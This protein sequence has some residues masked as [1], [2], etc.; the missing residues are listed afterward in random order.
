M[1]LRQYFAIVRKWWWL[2]A[3]TTLLATGTAYYVSSSAPPVYRATATLQIDRGGDPR[4]DPT[5]VIQTSEAIAST[6][7][8][9]IKSP[10]LL[11]EVRERLGV[12]MSADK[13][14]EMLIVSQMGD[15]QLINITA[16]GHDPTF[17]K[18]LVDMVAQVFIERETASQEAR[19]QAR[20]SEL[21]AQV[22]TLEAD[23]EET[24]KAI[25]SLGDPDELPEFAQLELARL[26]S[27]RSN[28][29]TRLMILLQS[30]EEFR[31]AMARYTTRIDIFDPAELPKEPVG[32]EVLQTTGLAAVTGLMIGAGVAFLLEYLDDT[33]KTP[34]DAKR[35]L[36]VNVLG[37][38]PRHDD[39][40]ETLVTVKRP[41]GPISEA[42]RKLRTSIQF[43]DLDHPMRTLLVTSP[44]PTDG[45]SFIATNLAV[46]IAQSG[47][48]VIL[49][50]SDLRHPV[51]HR[52]FDLPKFPGLREGL[53]AGQDLTGARGENEAAVPPDLL[54]ATEVEGLQILTAGEHTPNPAEVLGSQTFQRFAAHLAE[55]ADYV[56]FD[57]P[58][59][60]AVTDAVVL[61]H[62]TDGVILVLD[63]GQTRIPAAAQAM[64]R[65]RGVGSRVLGAVL[66]RVPARGDGYYY[67]QY[68]YGGEDEET[69]GWLDG[70]LGKVWPGRRARS[71]KRRERRSNEQGR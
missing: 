38:L 20:L 17:V 48:S 60:L 11:Q 50:D 19:F 2:L 54:Q 8:I 63:C 64:E 56:I 4:D 16:E 57:S 37:G 33:I 27:Q 71:S 45:K 66:N 22:A 23:I 40:R 36:D 26:E 10:G 35:A 30:A 5:R 28:Q 32:P 68:Y 69:Q 47:K 70:L 31:L 53:I 6:Y 18:A 46:T 1:E 49:V 58:P 59:V 3:L 55:Q 61:S 25:A 52:A 14:K 41:Q 9:Q 51:Q 44:M 13:I 65:L 12:Q 62:M 43:T 7:V 29:Q 34:L 15:T 39:D 42:F 24:Q 67:Y 21:E